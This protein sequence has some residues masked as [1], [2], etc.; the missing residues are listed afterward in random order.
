MSTEPK[1]QIQTSDFEV[2]SPRMESYNKLRML[3]A[4]DGARTALT[5]LA[6]CAGVTVL[7][8]SADALSVYQATHAPAGSLLPLWPDEFDMRPTVAFVA[9]GAIVVCAN[10]ASI[11]GGRLSFV[12]TDFWQDVS[13]S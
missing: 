5:A 11:L 1:T 6:L 10:L 13:S 7:A 4:V 9:C 12:S 3:D 8:L 2:D